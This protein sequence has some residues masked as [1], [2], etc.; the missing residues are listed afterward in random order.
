MK[1][2]LILKA[3]FLGT[4]FCLAQNPLDRPLPPDSYFYNPNINTTNR[5]TF[6]N[7]DNSTSALQG[8]I[9][10]LS[11]SGG[12]VLTI[13]P[14]TYTLEEVDIKT[15]VH[16]RVR[17]NVVFKSPLP[18]ETIFSVGF[19][20]NFRNISNWSFQSTNGTKCTFDFTNLQPNDKIRAFKLG[21]TTNFKVADILILDNYTKFNALS[22]GAAGSSPAKFA[23]FGIIENMDIKNAHYGYGLTQ[24]QVAQ[25]MLFRN[26][27]GEGGVTLRLESGFKG[28]ANLYLTDKTPIINN[29]YAR[30][31]SCT[32]GSHAVMLSPHTIMQGMVDI[33]DVSGT[34]CQAV[35]SISSGFL[36]KSKGQVDSNGNP[37]DGHTPGT[38]SEESVVA[39][40][41]A[42]YGTK[43]QTRG[44]RLRYVPCALRGAINLS[45]NPDNESYTSPS[46][47]PVLYLSLED[48][49]SF[50]NP[51][52]KFKIVLDNL[53]HTGFSSEV[54][55]DGLITDGGEND[56]EGCDID[57]P[58]IFI[59]REDRNTPNPLQTSTKAQTLNIE[60]NEVF[61]EVKVYQDSGSNK[62][63]IS[64]E[65]S[66]EINLYS[67]LG[68]LVLSKKSK[69]QNTELDVSSLS[70]GLY[71]IQLKTPDR[72]LSKKI[73]LN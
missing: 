62:L 20:N 66:T 34:S 49:V 42:T 13:S 19:A 67:V 25:D 69:N 63:I 26:L 59:V 10:S 30:N 15:G 73:I 47:A 21:N 9:D 31:I 55:A 51:A 58:P 38:F 6:P 4:F 5:M 45:I 22:S 50:N 16:I 28:L 2:L 56:F 8:M 60:K 70:K 54:R 40:I 7:G 3:L 53:T 44:G 43:A 33:R 17:P 32:N 27:S 36:S 68:K 24:N 65:A 72:K 52:G 23:T 64:S 11:S 57:G 37:L 41:S 35:V 18:A 61:G 1:S 71:I 12:G 29:V 39:N 14:G 48:Y 46:I